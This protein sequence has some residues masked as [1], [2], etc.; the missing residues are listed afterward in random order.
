M[1]GNKYRVEQNGQF[2][3]HHSGHE[4]AEAIAKAVDKYGD[5]YKINTNDWFDVYRGAHHARIYVGEE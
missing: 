4:P 5:C 1:S 2:L 3:G